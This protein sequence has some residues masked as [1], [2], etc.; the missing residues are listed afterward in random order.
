MLPSAST[1][2]GCACYSK[3]IMLVFCKITNLKGFLEECTVSKEPTF[4][5]WGKTWLWIYSR[6]ATLPRLY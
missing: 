6:F 3:N 1:F 5:Q 4:T 2:I